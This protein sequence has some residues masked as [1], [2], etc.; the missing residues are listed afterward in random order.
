MRLLPKFLA[1]SRDERRLLIRATLLTSVVQVSL[2]RLPFTMLRRLVTGGRRND[3]KGA[4][5][6][7]MLAT[8]VVWAVTAAS[9]R[10]P[11]SATC[12]SRALT[13]HAMLLRRGYPSCLHIGVIRSGQGELEGHAWVESEG[14]ILIGGTA[15]EIGHF[16][17]LA[18]FGAET[19]VTQG[20]VGTV[21]AGR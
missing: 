4:A 8:Q 11:G 12:L 10:V 16:T 9:R 6:D 2:G 3:N 15:S 7:P 17:P 21:Q 14:R 13:V 1:L 5:G 18:A 19:A 20:T